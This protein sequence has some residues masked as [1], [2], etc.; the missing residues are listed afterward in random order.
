MRVPLVLLAAL[1]CNRCKYSLFFIVVKHFIFSHSDELDALKLI[2]L[3]RTE[4]EK[5]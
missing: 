2:M 1:R 4:C 3:I 5:H